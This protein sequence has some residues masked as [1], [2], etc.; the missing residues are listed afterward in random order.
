M[1]ILEVPAKQINAEFHVFTIHQSKK[2]KN[3]H[4]STYLD[5]KKRKYI[6]FYN[7]TYL[8]FIFSHDK[9]TSFFA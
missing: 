5:K 9:L 3:I 1:T 6:R 7:N 2:L 8:R 4:I